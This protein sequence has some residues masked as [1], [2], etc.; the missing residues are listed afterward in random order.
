MKTNYIENTTNTKERKY[1]LQQKRQCVLETI[2]PICKAF[3]IKDYDYVVD[4]QGRERLV[5]EGQAIGCSH[6][7]IMATVDELIGYIFVNHYAEHRSLGAF[8]KQT[9][10]AIKRYWL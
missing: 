6:N 7:S 3:D 8:E 9:L 10:N 1:Y 4:E 5:V 2:E